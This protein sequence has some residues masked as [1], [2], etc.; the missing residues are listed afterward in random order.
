MRHK[1]GGNVIGPSPQVLQLHIKWK[2]VSAIPTLNYHKFEYYFIEK[3][4]FG[5]P[6]LLMIIQSF[7]HRYTFFS[8]SCNSM[9]DMNDV[10]YICTITYIHR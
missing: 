3:P 2:N 5:M 6:K 4:N 8:L 7:W 10:F 1:I 9:C